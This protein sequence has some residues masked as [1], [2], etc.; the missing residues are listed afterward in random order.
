MKKIIVLILAI[1]CLFAMVSCGETETPA[2][3]TAT[4]D[5]FISALNAT[6]PDK[7]DIKVELV[8]TL[9]TLNATYNVIYAEGGSAAVNYSREYFLEVG[10]GNT[11][12]KDTVSGTVAVSADGKFSDT[13]ALGGQGAIV[14][15]KITLDKD[16]MTYTVDGSVL[17][18]RIT[19]ANTQSVLGVSI[20]ADVVLTITVANGTVSAFSLN[21]EIGGARINASCNYIYN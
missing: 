5:T 14:N 11:L 7:A 12:T 8:S 1:A 16:K 18:A 17:T 13:E 19:Q 21:Y 4:V 2:G 3:D 15:A 6:N 10:E 20:E 9:G